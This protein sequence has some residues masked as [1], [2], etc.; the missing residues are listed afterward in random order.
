MHENGHYY[1][2]NGSIYSR[3]NGA[4]MIDEDATILLDTECGTLLKIGQKQSVTDYFNTMVTKYLEAGFADI[5][6]GL[7]LITFQIKYEEL[8]FEPDGYNLNIDE[9][10]TL[11]NWFN[12]CVGAE[13][14]KWFLSL[15]LEQ[16]KEHI[17]KLTAFDF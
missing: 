6:N 13:R 12:N 2:E 17:K 8:G 14:M 1:V 11:I 7:K 5:A 9:V 16:I 3:I 10:C 15:D 4:F